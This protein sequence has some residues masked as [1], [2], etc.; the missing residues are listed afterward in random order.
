MIAALFLNPGFLFVAAALIS[1]PI[2]IHLINR[3]RFKRIQWAAMEFLLKAQKRT[4]RRLIIEQLLLLAL[5]CFLLALVGLLVSRFVGCGDANLSG[6]P[7]IHIVV[8]DDTLSMSDTV[9]QADGTA[10]SCFD[11]AKTDILIKKIAKGLSGATSNDKLVLVPLSRIDDPTFEES[12]PTFDRLNDPENLKKVTQ[13]VNE[14]KPSMMHVEMLRGVKAA[15][16]IMAKFPESQITLH[17]LS[18]LRDVDWKQPDA[19]ALGKELV[20]IA[21]SSKEVRV[22]LIDCALPAR[23]ANQNG[24]PPSNDNVGISEIRPSTRIAGH[25][26]PVRF[27]VTIQN[28]S[29][30]AIDVDL[31]VRD[32][33]EGRDLLDVDFSPQTPIKLSPGTPT[34]V[35]FERGDVKNKPFFPDLKAGETKFAHLSVRLANRAHAALDNDGI[36]GDNIRHTVVEVRHKVPILVID[37]AGAD[38]RKESKDSFIIGRSLISVPGASYEVVYGDEISKSAAT[39]ALAKTDLSKY[40]TIYLLNAPALSNQELTNLEN[41]VKEGGGL[42]IFV[43]DI[44]GRDL[45]FY[46]EKLYNEGKG[47]FPAPI[48]DVFPRIGEKEL[49]PK[50]SDTH[51]LITREDLALPA[52]ENRLPIFGPMFD[53]PKQREPLMNLPI[54]RYFKVNIPAW[55]QQTN[56]VFELATLP[57]ENAAVDYETAV[58]SITRDGEPYKAIQTK[59]EFA[60]YRTRLVALVREVEETVRVG[61]TFKAY[62]LAN[63]IDTLLTDKGR[64]DPKDPIPDMTQLWGSSD[65]DVETVKRQLN[66]LRKEVRYGDPFVIMRKFGKGKV[67]AVMSTAGK[68]W[69]DWPG[70]CAASVLFPMFTWELQNYLS[71]PSGNSNLTVGSRVNLSVDADLFKGKQLK[72]QRVFMRP[73]NEKGT[74]EEVIGGEVGEEANGRI[75]FSMVNTQKPGLYF[76]KIVDANAQEDAAPLFKLPYV[77]NVDTMK[78]GRLQRIGDAELKSGYVDPSENA[79]KTIQPGAPDGDL[80]PRNNDFSESPWLFLILLLVLVAEQALAVHLSFHL[81]N[82]ESDMTPAGARVG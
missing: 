57:N 35:F 56:Q 10:K 31:V 39:K 51:Q 28:F 66:A 34:T 60:K 80:V 52:G 11:V 72:L 42:G 3:M 78:E 25:K 64:Q 33:N 29:S 21:K 44:A 67:V 58:A 65:P 14:M 32:E 74:V 18:D 27:A 68:D 79:I 12:P 23:A 62:H 81:K 46:N 70:G 69:N 40:P 16:A 1:V 22:R 59:P 30:N 47:L 2:I 61:G 54:R 26:M 36:L 55:K 19:E 48:K 17:I 4:R 76:A 13:E 8:V 50:E 24:Y 75:P 15:K 7:N 41:Y 77:F 37:G 73:G 45:K 9:K 5:R 6:K 20:Q 63:Q 38:G 71:S 43:G 49:S 82:T 53:E